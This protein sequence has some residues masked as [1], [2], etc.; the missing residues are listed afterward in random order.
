MRTRSSSAPPKPIGLSTRRSCSFAKSARPTKRSG[1]RRASRRCCRHSAVGQPVA[2]FLHRRAPRFPPYRSCGS[3]RL[4]LFHSLRRPRRSPP[5]RNP[6]SR[7]RRRH[8]R[9]PAGNYASSPRRT[10]LRLH[11]LRRRARVFRSMRSPNSAMPWRTRA[12]CPCRRCGSRTPV[13]SSAEHPLPSKPLRPTV[14][15]GRPRS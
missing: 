8:R 15:W 13:P 6:P 4:R 14:P 1:S 11:L 9:S 10:R 7:T 2:P 5:P 3:R 12:S